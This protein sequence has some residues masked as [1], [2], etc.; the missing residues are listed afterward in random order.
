M[1]E[2]YNKFSKLAANYIPLSPISFLNRAE[3]LHGSRTAVIYG[4]LR[5]NWAEQALRIRAL[6][7]GFASIGI[8]KGDTVSVLCP[9]IPELF[10]LHFS[11]PLS[12][13]VINTLNTR[14]EAETIAYILGHADSKVV[15]VDRQLI[16]LLMKAF[17]LMGQSLPVIE[18]CDLNIEYSTT[19]NGRNYEDLINSSELDANLGLPEDEWDAIS[20]NYTSGTSGRPKGVVYHH[21]GAYLMALGTAAA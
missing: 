14:L 9:N 18:I 16:P 20:L 19:L 11:L 6:A 10:E 5:R 12:G 21:R 2:H 3:S 17:E 7:N 8:R 15:I 1:Q 13:A 4:D